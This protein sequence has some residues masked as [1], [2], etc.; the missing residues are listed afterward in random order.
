MNNEHSDSLIPKQPASERDELFRYADMSH[1]LL[2]ALY[3][4]AVA[5]DNS[6]EDS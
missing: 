1:P 5:S 6:T 4:V 2:A 3:Q